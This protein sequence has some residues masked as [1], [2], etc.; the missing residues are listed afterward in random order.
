MAGRERRFILD[1]F[2]P[3]RLTGEAVPTCSAQTA[4]KGFFEELVDK[5]AASRFFLQGVR[6]ELEAARIRIRDRRCP[7]AADFDRPP[8]SDLLVDP[9]YGQPLDVVV[10]EDGEVRIRPAERVLAVFDGAGQ[11]ANGEDLSEI[12]FPCPRLPGP[13]RAVGGG[14]STPRLWDRPGPEG[15]GLESC[16]G[17]C[18]G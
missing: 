5:D 16:V 6:L 13:A 9:L 1:L 8:L 15:A 3:W 12:R 14:A 2:A 11:G 10:T 7:T 17:R 4:Y 18:G